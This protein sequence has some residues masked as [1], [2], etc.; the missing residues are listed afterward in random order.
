M[1]ESC[2]SKEEFQDRATS[3]FTRKR[4][5]VG[6]DGRWIQIDALDFEKN[7]NSTF[8]FRSGSMSYSQFL[9]DKKGFD[10]RDIK[11]ERCIIVARDRKGEFL[12]QTI[13]VTV[14]RTRT[15]RIDKEIKDKEQMNPHSRLE[16]VNNFV[17]SFCSRTSNNSD[18]FALKIDTR[19][20]TTN[21]YVIPEIELVYSD[22]RKQQVRQN[23]KQFSTEFVRNV[24]GFQNNP[25]G[26]NLGILAQERRTGDAAFKFCGNYLYKRGLNGVL[27]VDRNDVVNC[28][29]QE[30]DVRNT[31]QKLRVKLIIVVIPAGKPGSEKKSIISR[32][33]GELNISTQFIVEKNVFGK[34][35]P[36]FGMMDDVA[37]KIGG[38][39]FNVKYPFSR[40][41]KNDDGDDI[42]SWK[43]EDFWAV[44]I[45]VY[46]P[47]KR[48]LMSVLTIRI[49]CD[50]KDAELTNY[51]EVSVPLPPNETIA[52]QDSYKPLMEKLFAQIW[53]KNIP[54]PKYIVCF[55]SGVS[56][57]ETLRL[58]TNEIT[59][60]IQAM[61]QFYK[62]EKG[63]KEPK[64]AYFLTPKGSRVR[65]SKTR[66]PVAVVENITNGVFCDFYTQL[67]VEAR[68]TPRIMQYVCYLTMAG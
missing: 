48:E 5:L 7:E 1:Y 19:P 63:V 46:R 56:M 29:Y 12:P 55:R 58:R 52:N 23:P 26:V 50:I 2:S 4:A 59:A 43:A 37:S 68:L 27:N 20:I 6:Y 67:N 25:G 9:M 30:N 21:A 54:T 24:G 38:I 65:F 42:E 66:K 22:K 35:T 31:L 45:D 17:K 10:K 11:S 15:T 51:V 49:D 57:G 53:D 28:R 8:D 13:Y 62:K 39:W 44:G 60:T 16:A 36:F 32:V 40:G 18:G 14:D 33:A 41:L 34:P 47:E 61:Y 64:L 3:E